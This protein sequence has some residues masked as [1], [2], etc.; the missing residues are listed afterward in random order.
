MTAPG[1]GPAYNYR[2][3]QFHFL[4]LYRSGEARHEEHPFTIAS[5]P[6][7]R[8]TIC[9]SI[10]SSGDYTATIGRTIAGD[11]AALLGPFPL[12]ASDGD[13]L[14]GHRRGSDSLKQS[15]AAHGRYRLSA[16]LS[17]YG[18][19]TEKDIAFCKSW[20]RARVASGLG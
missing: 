16:M 1:N 8:S 5:S 11:R 19:R 18:N 10:K 12:S 15:A 2:P 4:T 7:N 20:R 14:R 13:Q 17:L 3:G 9:C 6:A